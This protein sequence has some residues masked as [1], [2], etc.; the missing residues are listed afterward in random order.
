ML[1]IV[2]WSGGDVLV[3]LWLRADDMLAMHDCK[4]E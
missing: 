2:E 3:M 4:N 1:A